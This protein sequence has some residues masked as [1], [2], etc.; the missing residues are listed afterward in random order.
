MFGLSRK[1]TVKK[2]TKTVA[3]RSVGDVAC[4]TNSSA[5]STQS[6]PG[7]EPHHMNVDNASVIEQQYEEFLVSDFV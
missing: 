2:D 7:V 4:I 6:P 3:A 1:N 5:S